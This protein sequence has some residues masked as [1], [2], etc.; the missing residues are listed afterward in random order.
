MYSLERYAYK[1]GT[2]DRMPTGLVGGYFSPQSFP[3]YTALYTSLDMGSVPATKAYIDKLK[4]M[5]NLMPSPGAVISAKNAGKAGKS[6]Y[7][8]EVGGYLGAHVADVATQELLAFNPQASV[9]FRP[10]NGTW[11]TVATDVLGFLTWGNNGGRGGDYANDGSIRFSGNSGWYPIQTVESYNGQRS[12]YQGNFVDWFSQNAFG[13]VNYEYTPVGAVTHVEEPYL[14][15]I[16]SN[17]Y[18][19]CWDEGQLFIDCAWMSRRVAFMMAVGD[20]WVTK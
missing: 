15:R 19:R 11:I 14:A 17:E 6:Y 1:D 4:N 2:C 12:T 9:D 5:Y 13:S 16:N 7:F 8:E 20:P 10:Q 3:G 18:F